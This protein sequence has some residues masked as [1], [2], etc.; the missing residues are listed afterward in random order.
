MDNTNDSIGI[1]FFYIVML[2]GYLLPFW[3]ALYRKHSYKWVI[4]ALIIGGGWTG[5]LWIASL[6]WAV[7]PYNKSLADPLLGNVTGT[8]ERNAGHTLGEME[9]AR[10]ESY[11]EKRSESK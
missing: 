9:Y 10:E 7:W 3:I 5:L 2:G 11:K 8:G 4:L 1:L 6:V